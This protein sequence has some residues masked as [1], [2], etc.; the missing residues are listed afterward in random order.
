MRLGGPGTKGSGSEE[1]PWWAPTL[2]GGGE[3][4][5]SL[6][7][8][9]SAGFGPRVLT[10][11]PASS[12]ARHPCFPRCGSETHG[13]LGAYVLGHAREP[14]RARWPWAPGAPGVPLPRCTGGCTVGPD[15]T[16]FVPTS[17][18]ACQSP[19]GRAELGGGR[20]PHDHAGAQ[21]R[22]PGNGALIWFASSGAL[23][24]SQEFTPEWEHCCRL[25]V[26]GTGAGC[27]GCTGQCQVEGDG[28][29]SR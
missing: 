28:E 11:A 9:A 25:R 2:R 3:F 21:S 22:I 24:Q 13:L 14:R 5:V 29:S 19:L 20:C 8:A 12:A 15:P 27:G 7:S 1:R 18:W 4:P 10:R 6:S 16:T 26:Q 17:C 23:S